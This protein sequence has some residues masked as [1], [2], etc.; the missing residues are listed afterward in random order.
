MKTSRNRILVVDDD[1]A[2][3]RLADGSFF[4]AWYSDASGDAELWSR[5]SADG[6][7]WDA[8]ELL[9]EAAGND[10]YPSLAQTAD[11]ALHLAW[12]KIGDEGIVMNLAG[13]AIK[14][15]ERG[16]VMVDVTTEPH[17]GPGVSL[18]VA[19]RDTGPG[20]PKASTP[21]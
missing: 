11:G 17:S 4:L 14:F 9:V 18:H 20:I 7:D 13:N 5:R 16:E 8:P 15:T 6:E 21:S 3:L 1:P 10:F 12:Q 2:L 19:V